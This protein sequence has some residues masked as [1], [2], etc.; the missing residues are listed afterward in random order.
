MLGL[1]FSDSRT[2][3]APFALWPLHTRRFK[4]APVSADAEERGVSAS[5]A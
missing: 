2:L 4:I 3:W 5:C 1:E